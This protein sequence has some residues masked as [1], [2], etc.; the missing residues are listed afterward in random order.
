MLL[1]IPVKPIA[2]NRYGNSLDPAFIEFLRNDLDC[3]ASI[4]LSKALLKLICL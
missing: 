1:G 3:G 4:R 2:E